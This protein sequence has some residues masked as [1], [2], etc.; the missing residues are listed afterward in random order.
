VETVKV[1]RIKSKRMDVILIKD[2]SGALIIID[3]SGKKVFL[4]KGQARLFRNYIKKLNFSKIRK[5][6]TEKI[7]YVEIGKY[8]SQ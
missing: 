7:R 2:T 5:S 3:P 4:S 8:V 1:Y 6:K